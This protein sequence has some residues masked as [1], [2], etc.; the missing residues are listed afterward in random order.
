MKLN[1][2]N[3]VTP[4]M[5]GVFVVKDNCSVGVSISTNTSFSSLRSEE[6]LSAIMNFETL[7]V[8]KL[9]ALTG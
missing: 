1:Q 9:R 7:F 2:G 3:V 4:G 8:F 5:P 6:T